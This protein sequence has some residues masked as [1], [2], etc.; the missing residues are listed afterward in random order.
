M[1]DEVKYLNIYKEVRKSLF[2]KYK[3]KRIEYYE[4]G[5]IIAMKIITKEVNNG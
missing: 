3:D 2:H 4:D 5:F 1:N